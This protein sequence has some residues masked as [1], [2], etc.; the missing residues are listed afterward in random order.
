M[1]LVWDAVNTRKLAEHGLTTLD[2]EEAL[3]DRTRFT[4]RTRRRDGQQASQD[5]KRFR[6]IG[7]T[8]A[9]D[10]VTVILGIT[11]EQRPRVVTAYPSSKRDIRAYRKRV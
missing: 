8:R 4:A 7:K 5:T 6:V 10:F 11:L 1:N 3:T 9:G 2:V